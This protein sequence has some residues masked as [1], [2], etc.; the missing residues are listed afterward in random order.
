MKAKVQRLRGMV[1]AA[2]NNGYARTDPRYEETKL[3]FLPNGKFY[4]KVLSGPKS[5]TGNGATWKVARRIVAPEEARFF[6]KSVKS[7]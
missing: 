2:T 3:C 1:I 7:Q 5:F 4:L 6:I